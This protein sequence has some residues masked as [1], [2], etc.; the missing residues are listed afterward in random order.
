MENIRMDKLEWIDVI[1]VALFWPL[2][3]VLYLVY[4]GRGENERAE[5]SIM[6]MIMAILIYVTLGFLLG[7]FA[8]FVGFPL[9]LCI[10]YFG[11]QQAQQRLER[12]FR[13]VRP[14]TSM[15]D[16]DTPVGTARSSETSDI[17]ASC[18]NCGAAL[19]PQ[20]T[21]R[22]ADGTVRCPYCEHT[23]QVS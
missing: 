1:L 5:A 22:T 10:Y 18:P 12:D 11:T 20:D 16:E 14:T 17:P 19:Q 7:G 9:L 13:V 21:E 8:Y 2:G 6:A 3:V 23:M 15:A 4:K